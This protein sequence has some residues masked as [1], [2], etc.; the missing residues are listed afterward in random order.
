MLVKDLT[1]GKNF[2]NSPHTRYVM[3]RQAHLRDVFT[4]TNVDWTS[5]ATNEDYVKALMVLFKQRG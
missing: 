5:V 4:K 2:S 1:P 3:E